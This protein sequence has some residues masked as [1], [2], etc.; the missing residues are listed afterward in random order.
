MRPLAPTTLLIALLASALGPRRALPEAVN[1]RLGGPGSATT[2]AHD[3]SRLTPDGEWAI[4]RWDL[5]TDAIDELFAIRRDGRE[6]HRLSAPTPPVDVISFLVSP[7]SR[8]VVYEA[9]LLSNGVRELWSVPIAGPSLTARLSPDWTAGDGVVDYAISPD[10]SRVVTYGDFEVPGI[11]LLS[12]AAIAGPTGSAVQL[13]PAPVA[14]GEVFEFQISPDSTRVVF[15]GDLAQVDKLEYWSVPIAGPSGSAVRLNSSIPAGTSTSSSIHISPDSTRVVYTGSYSTASQTELWSVPIAG[16][17]S[18]SRKLNPSVVA[19]GDV[20]TNH[21]EITPDSAYV[22]FFGDLRVDERLEIWSVPI[23]GF[24]GDAVRLNPTPVA[25]GTLNNSDPFVISPDSSWLVMH[26]DLE[27]DGA[28]ELWRVPIAGPASSAVKV[29]P[30]AVAGGDV[31][32]G[33]YEISPD[34]EFVVFLGDLAS[35]DKVELWSAAR[36]AAPETAENLS[37]GLT[38][39]GDVLDFQIA[40]DSSRAV[41]RGDLVFADKRWL[42]SHKLD[43]SGG[44]QFLNSELFSNP[45]A[46]VD[47][48]T[49]S[50]DSRDVLYEANPDDPALDELYR[51]RIADGED[52]QHLSDGDPV[53]SEARLVGSSP[54]G[55]GAL[56]LSDTEFDSAFLLWIADDWI[57]SANFEEGN[58][59]EWSSSVP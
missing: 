8:Y 49:I 16:P 6:A 42:F 57:L 25:G 47:D 48:W 54:D 7:D 13:S 55:R 22:V 31:G 36:D 53:F 34:S 40:P 38:T 52:F 45:D 39:P 33:D 51:R 15:A 27:T 14:N 28:T 30:D 23:D 32:V 37:A 20:R 58:F 3:D 35:D 2:D 41:F 26:G 59:T 56:Y 46:D 12:S 4:V 24:F 11:N 5:H 10:S 17:A 43:G 29:H 1:T 21:L 44:R 9:E 19:G 18:S 50:A